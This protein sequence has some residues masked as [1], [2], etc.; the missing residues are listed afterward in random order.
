MEG[1]KIGSARFLPSFHPS[2]QKVSTYV[3]GNLKHAM[4]AEIFQF[5]KVMRRHRVN[6]DY[7]L[8]TT[9][10]KND[11]ENMFEMFD[12]YLNECKRLLEVIS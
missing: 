8:R 5:L 6:A 3:G 12:D 10:S 7:Q 2:I 9:T 4:D 1:W 11:V